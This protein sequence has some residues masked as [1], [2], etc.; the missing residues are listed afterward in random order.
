MT[1][2]PQ[3]TT[4]L[5]WVD[6]HCHVENN[7]KGREAISNAKEA[8]VNKLVNVGTD[9]TTSH[10]ALSLSQEF[11]N[12]VFSTAGV[13]PHE[14]TKGL[15]GIRD[16]LQNSNVVAVGECGLDYHYNYSPPPI[17]RAI[18]A[19]HI[20]LAHEFD[21]PLI[22]HARDAWEEIFSILE[23][24]EP[25]ARTVFH[26]FTGGPQEAEKA[27]DLGALLSFSGIVTFKNAHEI[28]EAMLLTPI[29][30]FMIETDSP[31]LAPVPL[32][33]QQNSP[34]NLP[35]IGSY[36]AEKRAMDLK[37]LSEQ[38]WETTH[39][40]YRIPIIDLIENP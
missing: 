24:K 36:I 38:L 7:D 14:A 12:S 25:P 39:S 17:Q 13:H 1:T 29:D 10:E 8:G 19:E 32:R 28:Q 11:P 5:Q 26:C 27:L 31:Y 34:C 15:T 2:E 3:Q 33:G 22:I 23:D 37:A 16:L 18:F 40:F 20:D 21:L 30:R 35:I 6:N 4:S 9:L